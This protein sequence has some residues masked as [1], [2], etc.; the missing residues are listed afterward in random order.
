MGRWKLMVSSTVFH[1][2]PIRSSPLTH[3]EILETTKA[4]ME[5]H[6]DKFGRLFQ[7]IEADEDSIPSLTTFD[8]AVVKFGHTTVFE[9]LEKAMKP[10]NDYCKESNLCPFM[11]AASYKESPACV[12]NHLLRGDLSW[13][14]SCTISSLEGNMPMNKKTRIK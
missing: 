14:N 9:V 7:T 5:D 2:V 11:I 3:W 1:Q 12:I 6:P 4:N 10:L 13:V 8:I